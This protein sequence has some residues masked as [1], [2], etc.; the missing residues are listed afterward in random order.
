MQVICPTC[1]QIVPANNIELSNGLAKCDACAQIF[2]FQDLTPQPQEQDLGRRRTR[3]PQP[4][5]ILVEHQGDELVLNWRWFS[6]VTAIFMTFFTIA[7]NVF[8]I[9]WYSMVLT[10]PETPW[11]MVVFPLGHVAVGIGLLYY[12]LGLFV[13]RTLIRVSRQHLAL[14][15][16]PLF[17][18]GQ[19]DL[20]SKNITQLFC[21][22]KVYH[23]KNGTRVAYL[24]Y[25]IM[26]N[27]KEHKLVE[28]SDPDHAQ[29]IEQQIEKKLGL[30]D[31][32][33]DGEMAV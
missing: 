11:L 8:L 20:P 30:V 14:R 22:R 32:S 16:Q 6:P 13:N 21:R 10:S 9:F 26:K 23:T 17:W 1:Q 19:C 27:H 29:Y 18:T 25:V 12:T 28:V 24:V 7:W 33:I 15:H 2:P 5:N 3:I 31:Q 4:E